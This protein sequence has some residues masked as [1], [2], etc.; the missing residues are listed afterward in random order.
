VRTQV[1]I[2]G[3]GPAGL[4]LQQLLH[5]AGIESVI[6]EQRSRAYVED[7]IRA[8]V[9]EPGTVALLDRVGVNARMHRDGLIHD[10]FYLSVDGE[11]LRIDLERDDSKLMHIRN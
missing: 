9:L 11:L 2:I 6:L 1:A 5:V 8:G 3:A 4:L 10:G 7:R